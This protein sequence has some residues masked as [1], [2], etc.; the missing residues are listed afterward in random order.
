MPKDAAADTDLD[1]FRDEARGWLEAN[2]P[3]SLRGRGP[4]L[5]DSDSAAAPAAKVL[6]IFVYLER[7]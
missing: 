5:A 1:A 7:F 3:P 4:T 6:Y 2:F